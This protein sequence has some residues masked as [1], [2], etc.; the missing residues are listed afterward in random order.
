M[1]EVATSINPW[2]RWSTEDSYSKRY[3]NLVEAPDNLN[4]YQLREKIVA[5]KSLTV[6]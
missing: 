2:S 3:P 6:D 4:T 5:V 1:D